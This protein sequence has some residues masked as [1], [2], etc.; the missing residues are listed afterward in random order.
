MALSAEELKKF[1]DMANQLRKNLDAAEYKH[2]VLGLVFLKHISDSFEQRRAQLE[3]EF[4]NPNSE[5]YKP[6]EK[7]RA[8]AL[9]SRDYYEQVNVFWVPEGAR[10]EVIAAN[11]KQP[12]LAQ[13]ID[14]ALYEVER[15]NIDR[16]EGIV[17]RSYANAKLPVADLGAVVDLIGTISFGQGRD[18]ESDVLGQVYEYFL[19][20]FAN[21]EGKLGGQFYTT[22]S[23]VKTIVEVLQ[24]TQGKVYDP[25][26]GSG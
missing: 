2:I 12:D 1:W 24:P 4:A 25:A 13:R 26:C 19:G 8:N 20:Q 21:A 6:N 15:E 10:W 3:A 16:L 23:I 7:A 17:Q 14:N 9:A 22:P 11:S 18:R 5:S